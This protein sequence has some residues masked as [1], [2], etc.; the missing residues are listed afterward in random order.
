MRHWLPAE[1]LWPVRTNPNTVL[2]Y[3]R[4]A[5]LL[6]ARRLSVRDGVPDRWHL[7]LATGSISIMAVGDVE[8]PLKR[9]P[10]KELKAWASAWLD[11]LQVQLMLQQFL[12]IDRSEPLTLVIQRRALADDA[13]MAYARLFNAG[14]RRGVVDLRQWIQELGDESVALHAEAMR[15]RDKH[16]AHRA[17]DDLE[18]LSLTLVWENFGASKPGLRLRLETATGPDDELAQDLLIMSKQL[19]DW[20]WERELWPRQQDW[21]NQLGPQAIEG[22][23]L[24]AKPF[25]DDQSNVARSL[26][27]TADIGSEQPESTPPY[28]RSRSRKN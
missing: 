25:Q 5:E 21:L 22:M 17:D 1:R 26:R 14:A 18:Y 19:A 20:V 2:R 11:L 12:E 13:L 27:L 23:R 10:T 4:F 16:I 6:P 7:P 28:Q 9:G 24:K 15:W 8:Y 3:S